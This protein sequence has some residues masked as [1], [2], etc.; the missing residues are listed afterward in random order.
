MWC[1]ISGA[2]RSSPR[3]WVTRALVRPSPEALAGLEQRPP[4][5]GLAQ[6][7]SHPGGL[8]LLRPL[9]RAPTGRDGADH[10]V[11]GYPAAC[12]GADVA[13]FEGPLGPQ[14]DL[15]RLVVVPGLRPQIPEFRRDMHDLEPDL[16]LREAGPADRR[17]GHLGTIEGVEST[18]VGF[19]AR[20]HWC[21]D[22]AAPAVSAS[23]RHAV[24]AC[25]AWPTSRYRADHR[26]TN[27][28]VALYCI[29]LSY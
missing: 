9:R 18:P 2:R 1:W 15:D 4:L 28:A 21:R 11:G 27:R 14:G 5:E 7:L 29:L 12:Q 20:A 13:V 3:I 24:C 8:G 23:I 6:Q 17:P 19:D 26:L 16:G 22:D 10:P 25:R